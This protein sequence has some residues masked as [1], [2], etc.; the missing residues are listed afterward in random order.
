MLRCTI[1]TN[2][3]VCVCQN[4]PIHT[5]IHSMELHGIICL[6]ILYWSS[7]LS[8][9]HPEEKLKLNNSKRKQIQMM[10]TKHEAGM[11][12]F[13]PCY[14]SRCPLPSFILSRTAFLKIIHHQKQPTL[15]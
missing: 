6:V 14:L 15:F 5:Y 3:G 12:T 1:Y 9:I 10:N 11:K 2:G 8:N 13:P 4:E 7:K